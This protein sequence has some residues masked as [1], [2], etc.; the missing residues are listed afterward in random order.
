M[1]PRDVIGN[2]NASPIDLSIT[3]DDSRKKTSKCDNPKHPPDMTNVQWAWLPLNRTRTPSPDCA[4]DLLLAE[5]GERD[6]MTDDD[7][8]ILRGNSVALKSNYL[9]RPKHNCNI[10]GLNM[11][12]T[13]LILSNVFFRSIYYVTR[14][15]RRKL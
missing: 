3:I 14:S 8:V 1:T 2:S 10:V 13:E 5:I 4:Q 9:K 7:L 12:I 6:M 15:E 11:I